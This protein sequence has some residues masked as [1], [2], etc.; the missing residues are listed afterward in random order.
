VVITVILFL[1]L[2][3]RSRKKYTTTEMDSGKL[4]LTGEVSSLPVAM[5]R[6]MPPDLTELSMS[7]TVAIL[8]PMISN[9]ASGTNLPSPNSPSTPI[10][11]IPNEYTPP[12]TTAL[13]PQNIGEISQPPVSSRPDAASN[14]LTDEQTEFVHN[15]YN[16]SVPVPAIAGVINR[17]IRGNESGGGSNSR[18]TST[19]RPPEYDFKAGEGD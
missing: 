3:V 10:S 19:P 14:P 6:T 2:R 18:V 16:L 17:L 4:A 5:D 13:L 1:L 15:L 11:A 9:A 8:D 7:P 12:R